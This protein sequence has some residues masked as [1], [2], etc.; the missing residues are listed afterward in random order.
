[1][2][3]LV[4]L[5]RVTGPGDEP[6]ANADELIESH[7]DEVLDELLRLEAIDPSVDLDLTEHE[8]TLSV[9]VEKPNPIDATNA[10]SVLIR[11]AIHAANGSTPDWPG[12]L[13]KAWSVQLLSLSTDP[14]PV[15]K[16]VGA[17][18]GV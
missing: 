5:V 13:D 12:A 14:V 1:M 15:Q 10:A 16:A 17:L 11:T 2:V 7:L 18:V 4:G 3:S 9:L 8:V 6:I